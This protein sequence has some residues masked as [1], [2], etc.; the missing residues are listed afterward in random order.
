MFLGIILSSKGR[1][2]GKGV[3]ER[4]KGGGSEVTKQEKTRERIQ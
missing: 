3:R 1:E 2:V 4:G